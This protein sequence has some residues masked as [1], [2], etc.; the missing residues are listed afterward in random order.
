[1]TTKMSNK[2]LKLPAT[3]ALALFC[4]VSWNAAARDHNLAAPPQESVIQ[5]VPDGEQLKVKGIVIKRNADAFILRD[6]AGVDRVVALTPKTD[7]KSHKRGVLKGSKEYGLSYILR[8]L[9]LEASGKGNAQGQ[10]VAKELDF[11]EDDLKMAQALEIRVEPLETLAED[12]RRRITAAEEE[13]RRLALEL[14]KNKAT[15]Q[16]AMQQAVTVNTKV[17]GLED[18]NPVKT[19][20]VLFPTGSSTLGAKGKADIDAAAAWVKTQNTQGWV[21]AVVGFADTVG[22]NASNDALSERRATSVINYMVQKHNL[23]LQRLV[24]PYGYGENQP[25]AD[26]STEEGRAQNRRAEVRL[27]AGK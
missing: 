21:V 11:D 16:E 7:V 23:P 4:I 15:S 24:R 19:I 20:A 26:N 10:L 2:N 25:I 13:A 8:G 3:F 12:N 18:Y 1:M 22:N 6:K 5:Q 9:R 27:L 17:N 14:E